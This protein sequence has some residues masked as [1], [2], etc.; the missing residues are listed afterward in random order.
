MPVDDGIHTHELRPARIRGRKV[1]QELAVRIGAPR[2]HEDRPDRLVLA[3]VGVEGGAHWERIPCEVEMVLRR[4]RLHKRVHFGERV[5]WDNVYRLEESGRRRL[6]RAIGIGG[7][8]STRLCVVAIGCSGRKTSED[9]DEQDKAVFA[10]VI[11]ERQLVK[12]A[13]PRVSKEIAYVT[14]RRAEEKATPP[15]PFPKSRQK[16]AHA[17]I[18]SQGFVNHTHRDAYLDLHGLERLAVGLFLEK[19]EQLASELVADVGQPVARRRGI[20]QRATAVCAIGGGAGRQ[21]RRAAVSAAAVQRI[22]VGKHLR[23]SDGQRRRACGESTGPETAAGS[24]KTTKNQDQCRR[25][26]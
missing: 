17:R 13:R 11:G 24:T 16:E 9:E 10:A 19:G 14:L 23:N 15:P 1:R 4:R 18:T 6:C 2:A 26:W 8:A 22:P 20:R 7:G 3:E 21:P 5:W 12:S 25:M